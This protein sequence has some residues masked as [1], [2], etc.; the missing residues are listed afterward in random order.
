MWS[1]RVSLRPGDGAQQLRFS[2]GG[3]K[4]GFG[5]GPAKRGK[6]TQ[7]TAITVG[8]SSGIHPGGLRGSAGGDGRRGA[9]GALPGD[10]S[11]A[12]GRLF[13]D[14]L[15]GQD[16]GGVSGTGVLLIRNQPARL[17]EVKVNEGA[18][19]SNSSARLLAPP[20]SGASAIDSCMVAFPFF[21]SNS[22]QNNMMYDSCS[23]LGIATSKLC[24]FGASS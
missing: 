18:V 17:G 4:G 14:G 19:R 23:L 15:P 10:R 6:V 16:N 5:I 13:C 7:I 3:E 9:K 8:A 1:R 22:A 21:T 11:A 12:I 2:D 20:E 24:M